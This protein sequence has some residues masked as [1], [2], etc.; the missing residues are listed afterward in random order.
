[1]RRKQLKTKVQNY[2]PSAGR[3]TRPLAPEAIE[4]EDTATRHTGNRIGRL[5]QQG[6]AGTSHCTGDQAPMQAGLQTLF[7]TAAIEGTTGEYP[8]HL[9]WVLD[10]EL[11]RTIE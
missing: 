2:S 4:P 5:H 9:H 6:Y 8:I 7:V 10:T 3:E 1:M 11:P